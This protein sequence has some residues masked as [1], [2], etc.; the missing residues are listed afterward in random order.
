MKLTFCKCYRL[1]CK[2]WATLLKGFFPQRLWSQINII[3]R[4]LSMALGDRKPLM[5]GIDSHRYLR[6]QGVRQLGTGSQ[7]EPG[8]DSHPYTHSHIFR[9]PFIILSQSTV[10][11]SQS[12]EVEDVAIVWL[13]RKSWQYKVRALVSNCVPD[14]IKHP[15]TLSCEHQSWPRQSH[16]YV[17]ISA[18]IGTQSCD[19]ILFQLRKRPITRLYP[20]FSL[21]SSQLHDWTED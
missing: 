17:P 16:E 13:C 5:R 2:N 7:W 1:C 18:E 12:A 10:Y 4:A 9:A 11:S 3:Q 6:F 8:L 21:D 15:H 14:I 19:W 20:N